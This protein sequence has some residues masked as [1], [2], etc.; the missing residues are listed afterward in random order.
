MDQ[1]GCEL[2][3]SGSAVFVGAQ[4]YL[5]D[6]GEILPTH[7]QLIQGKV[8]LFL[9]LNKGLKKALKYTTP[10]TTPL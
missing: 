2:P 1:M 5:S 3:K 7:S 4:S 6:G 8:L 10:N 9:S